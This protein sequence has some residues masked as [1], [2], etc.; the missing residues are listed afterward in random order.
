VYKASPYRARG[1]RTTRNANDS[2]FANGGKRS[3]LSVKRSGAGYAASISMG[4][5]R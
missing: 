4:V 3:M 1:A 5:A 2:I